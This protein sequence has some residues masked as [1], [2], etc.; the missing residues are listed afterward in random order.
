VTIW[1]AERELRKIQR[2]VRYSRNMYKKKF[3][4][5]AVEHA[6]D[7]DRIADFLCNLRQI[8]EPEPQE[9]EE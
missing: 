5:V 1:E 3:R 4:H 2:S 7:I 9:T 8:F 6:D